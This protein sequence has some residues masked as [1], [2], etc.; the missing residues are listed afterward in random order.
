MPDHSGPDHILTLA[1]GIT[2]TF[3]RALSAGSYRASGYF[4]SFSIDKCIGNFPTHFLEVT[5]G[6]LP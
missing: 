3:A 1:T 6:S 2:V 4:N 5:P